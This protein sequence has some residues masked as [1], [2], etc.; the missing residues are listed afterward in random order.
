MGHP[1]VRL[2][3]VRLLGEAYPIRVWGYRRASTRR[4]T[5]HKSLGQA[6]ELEALLKVWEREGMVSKAELLAKLKRQK[7]EAGIAR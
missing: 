3:Y 6:F 4:L 2:G 5:G 7:E 1:R